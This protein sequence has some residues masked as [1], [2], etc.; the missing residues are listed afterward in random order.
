MI[1]WISEKIIKKKEKKA[2][3][4]HVFFLYATIFFKI[5]K[6]LYAKPIMHFV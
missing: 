6:R 2:G 5:V 3:L 1:T 4:P